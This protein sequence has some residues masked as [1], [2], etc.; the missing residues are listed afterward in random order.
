MAS[1][2]E[3]NHLMHT[4]YGGFL[5]KVVANIL[6]Y[7]EPCYNGLSENKHIN[8]ALE[9]LGR[10]LRRALSL[11]RFEVTQTLSQFCDKINET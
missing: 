4:S 2:Y 7:I 9:I 8:G 10:I 5:I 3:V 6:K 1:L 11:P